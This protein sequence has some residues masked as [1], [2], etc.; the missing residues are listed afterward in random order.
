MD[1]IKDNP[2]IRR[3]FLD[4]AICQQRIKYALSLSQ[5]QKILGQRN[6][7]L[8]D[9][10]GHSELIDTVSIWNDIL[11]QNGAVIL[12][13]R[14]KYIKKLNNAAKNFH[15]GISNGKEELNIE[16]QS[17]IKVEEND[18]ENDIKEKFLKILENN[19]KDDIRYGHTNAGPHR[20]DI[21]ITINGK[22][23]KI[24]SSQGQQRSAVLSLKLSEAQLLYEKNDEKPI[25]LLDDV[26]SE[27]DSSRQDYLLNKIEG[28]Q[29]FVTCCEKNEKIQLKNGRVFYVSNGEIKK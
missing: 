13:E 12:K 21:N 4:T 15:F 28:Y 1:L 27:L 10:F 8:K 7:L 19:I 20:D 6:A 29:V 24:Y 26:L 11:A 16:Y 18:S 5:Y 3:R 23:S 2:V 17:Q 14:T 25:I 22:L 9:V